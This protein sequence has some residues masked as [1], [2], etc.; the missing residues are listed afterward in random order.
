[1]LQRLI[2][3]VLLSFTIASC[4]GDNKVSIKK[5]GG[6]NG[7]NPSF[8]SK[9]AKAKYD[10]LAQAAMTSGRFIEINL[11]I[12]KFLLHPTE[13]RDDS[14]HSCPSKIKDHSKKD[15]DT[16]SYYALSWEGC[17]KNYARSGRDCVTIETFKKIN[18]PI[19]PDNIKSLHVYSSTEKDQATTC[20]KSPSYQLRSDSIGIQ[21]DLSIT[22]SETHL[23]NL[24]FHAYDKNQLFTTRKEKGSKTDIRLEFNSEFNG[25]FALPPESP[26]PLF[27]LNDIRSYFYIINEQG[28]HFDKLTL[29]SK[30]SEYN[31]QSCGFLIGQ[32]VATIES[33]RFN[34]TIAHQTI[35]STEKDLTSPMT[36]RVIQWPSCKEARL[37]QIPLIL[38]IFRD[39][40]ID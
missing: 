19:T 4:S 6:G 37:A 27:T 32:L 14:I 22:R 11:I 30:Q 33:N 38:Q 36:D 40:K 20:G 18:G 35:V 23:N 3:L 5:G 1:M 34:E 25:N 12:D 8:P 17:G 9:P 2:L 7:N 26:S 15:T 24:I 28:A 21:S 16:A 10:A 13:D 29:S 39:I 31:F